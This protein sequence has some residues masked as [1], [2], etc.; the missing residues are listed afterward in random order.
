VISTSGAGSNIESGP[1]AAEPSQLLRR[2]Q[3]VESLHSSVLVMPASQ[4]LPLSTA[5]RTLSGESVQ[6]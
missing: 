2:A 1:L 4:A 6:S 5:S 3:L